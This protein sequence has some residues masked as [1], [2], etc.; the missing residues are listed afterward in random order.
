MGEKRGYIL[1]VAPPKPAANG[2][3]ATGPEYRLVESLF[4]V[5]AW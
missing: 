4:G 3:P 1:E 2:K 5:F